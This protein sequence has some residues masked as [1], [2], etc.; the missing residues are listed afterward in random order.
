MQLAAFCIHL[1][2]NTF[3]ALQDVREHDMDLTGWLEFS[4][5]LLCSCDKL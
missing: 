1:T 5:S 4:E 3:P 2:E